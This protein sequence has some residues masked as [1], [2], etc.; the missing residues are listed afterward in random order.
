MILRALAGLVLAAAAL[1]L[2]H[3]ELAAYDLPLGPFATALAWIVVWL[4]C[5]MR[6]RPCP[7]A[8]RVSW[9]ELAPALIAIVFVQ[10]LVDMHTRYLGDALIA[11]VH[12]IALIVLLVCN[13]R[14]SR[15]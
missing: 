10:L 11:G 12:W 13:R 7:F 2:L 3:Y 5:R 1:A 9:Y 6:S 15:S 8:D 4:A 14:A